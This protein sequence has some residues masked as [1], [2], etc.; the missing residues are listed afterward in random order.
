[1]IKSIDTSYGG[2]LFRS[3]LEAR[4]G[5]Y[6]DALGI[7]WFYEHEGYDFGKERYLP[8]FYLPDFKIYAEIKPEKFTDAEHRKCRLLA[9]M[10]QKIVIELVGLP[11]LETSTVIIPQ[12]HFI[13]PIYGQQY[14]YADFPQSKKCKCGVYHRITN[15]LNEANGTLLLVN[16]KSSYIPIYYGSYQADSSDK[17]IFDAIRKAKEARFEFK[18]KK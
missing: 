12:Q 6:F 17:I 3:R 16:K 10:T 5:V 14:V 2:Y 7:K 8:D 1:M 11:N 9:N 15:T 18:D 13:C 4:F